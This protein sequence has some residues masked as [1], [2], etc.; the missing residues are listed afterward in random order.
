M[1]ESAEL[2]PVFQERVLSAIDTCNNCFGIIREERNTVPLRH[3]R[4]NR[5]YPKAQYSRD[6]RRTCVE[7]P[8]TGSPTK[9]KYVFC[10]CGEASSHDRFRSE[11]V[12]RE[13]FRELLKTAIRTVEAKGV[14]LSRDHA[15]RKALRLGLATDSRFPVYSADRAIAE[16]I[17]YGVSMTAVSRASQPQGQTAI[18]AD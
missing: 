5:T 7:Y 2:P 1:P 4:G 18:A 9:S 10:D 14:T 13:Q 3:Q 8:P 12:P 6:H 17:E 11:I 16:G 15:I